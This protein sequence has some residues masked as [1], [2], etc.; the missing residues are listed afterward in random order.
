MSFTE[1]RWQNMCVLTCLQDFCWYKQEDSPPPEEAASENL[2]FDVSNS[3]AYLVQEKWHVCERKK[4]RH[5]MNKSSSVLVFSSLLLLLPMTHAE[6]NPLFPPQRTT[7]SP[8]GKQQPH[9]GF[10]LPLSHLGRN[11]I[12]SFHLFLLGRVTTEYCVALVPQTSACNLTPTQSHH[13]FICHYQR[14][15]LW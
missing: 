2:Q 15:C 1:Q 4:G 9:V 12:K 11:E 10:A 13:P 6:G 7:I 3:V 14:F 8:V 5:R